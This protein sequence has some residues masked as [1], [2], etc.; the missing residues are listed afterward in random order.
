MRNIYLSAFFLVLLVAS[1][2]EHGHD[3]GKTSDQQESTNNASMVYDSIKAKKYGADELGMRKYVM[4]FLYAGPN[5]DQ[6]ES[7]QRGELMTAHLQNIGRMAEE[8]SL[9]LAGPFFGDQDLRGIYIFNVESIEEAEKLTNTDPA[10]QAGSL[11]MELLE[12]Y[13]S[14]AL[15]AVNEIHLTLAKESIVED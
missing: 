13:G 8:G 12:W 9:S 15:M 10:I 3:H 1:S 4:A 7:I 11:R 2:C 14:A 5:R 6:I